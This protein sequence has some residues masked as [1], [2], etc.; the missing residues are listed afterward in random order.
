[1]TV[2]LILLGIAT[3]TFIFAYIVNRTPKKDE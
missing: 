2:T 3:L 1:M